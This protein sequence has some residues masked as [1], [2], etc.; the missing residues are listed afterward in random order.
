MTLKTPHSFL[1]CILAACLFGGGCDS[2]TPA[3]DTFLVVQGFLEAEKPLP[4]FLLK[5]TTSLDE[6]LISEPEQ[7]VDRA[8]LILTVNETEIHYSASAD[9][10]G[11]YEPDALLLDRVPPGAQ[12]DVEI[13]WNNITARASDR[14]P[15]A[16]ALD[17]IQVRVPERSISAILVDT[18]RL[19]TP[20]VGARRGFIYLVEVDMWWTPANIQPQ[21]ST[22]WI[23]T[24]LRPQIDFS[25]KVL[26]VFLLVEEVQ[27]EYAI[28]QDHQFQ[29]KWTGVYAVPVSDSLAPIPDHDLTVQLLRGT[30]AYALFAASRNNPER[31]EPISN[32]DGAIGI[33]AGISLATTDVVVANG[34]VQ[35]VPE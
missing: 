4:T 8:S 26:D 2:I 25:S 23:E 24:R 19:D 33:I 15:A 3:N 10:P 21:D 29:R 11:V 31:R 12:F 14:V 7:F 20:E 17:S 22:F 28:T 30:D 6:N 34:R 13:A 5:Q 32:I 9:Q 16:I 18:L 1:L 35:E 27:P